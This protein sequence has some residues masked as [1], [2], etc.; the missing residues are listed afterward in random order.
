MN[1]VSHDCGKTSEQWLNVSHFI[2][3][4]KN[5]IV[6][7]Y[8]DNDGY[9][10]RSEGADSI[11]VNY[12]T[13]SDEE[14]QVINSVEDYPFPDSSMERY[15]SSSFSKEDLEGIVNPSLN[16]ETTFVFN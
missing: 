5:I 8:G 6:T 3:E 2:W 4:G 13:C 1:F 14:V 16:E 7:I 10:Y 9:A 15:I 12:Y 11:S